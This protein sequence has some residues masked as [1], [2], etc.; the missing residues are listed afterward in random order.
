MITTTEA[1]I[2]KSVKFRDSSKLLTAYSEE[3][4][5]CS[6]VANG[7][8]KAKNKFG[9]AL[10]PL[11]CSRLTFYKHPNKDLHTLSDAENALPMRNL[12]ESFDKLT[13]GLAML[14]AVY[15]TQFEQEKN[16]ELYNLLKFTLQALNIAEHNEHSLLV[17]FQFWLADV[18]GFALNPRQC[19]DT[20]E[21]I[22][23]EDAPE[24]IL[25]LADGAPFSPVLNTRRDGF[26]IEAGTLA[27]LQRL[28][29][30]DTAQVARVTMI[31]LSP[32]QKQ[33]LDDFFSLYYQYHLDRRI[34]DRTRR[35][36]RDM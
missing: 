22:S 24:F 9:S 17:W 27:I 7:A 16:T 18:L 33:Q 13:V 4:G 8:R 25:S 6:L 21:R 20:D 36:L 3:F 2:L 5:R 14:E 35:F 11:S 10:D 1:I 31:S 26:R 32:R 19:A 29:D 34:T 15:A 30:L 28:S 23:P 12:M